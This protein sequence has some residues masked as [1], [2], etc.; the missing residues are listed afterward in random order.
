MGVKSPQLIFWVTKNCV[1]SWVE[2]FYGFPEY[3][4][5]TKVQQRD[6]WS[7]HWKLFGMSSN[8]HK[9]F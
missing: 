9:L 6:R 5:D 1:Q 4:W 8:M 3:E 2:L 7:V